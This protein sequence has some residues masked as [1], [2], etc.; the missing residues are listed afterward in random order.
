MVAEMSVPKNRRD[1]SRFE[2]E[3]Q[4]YKLRR[5]V[6][7]LI[8]CDFGFH[9]E[10]YL[11]Q[12]ERYREN[13]STAANVDEIC[14]RWEAKNRSFNVWFIDEEGRAILDLLRKISVEF[15][16]GNSI[17][18]SGTHAKV[19]EYLQ[20]RYHI[21]QAIGYCYALKHEIQYAIE[22][23]PVDINKYERF[24]MMIDK[25]IALYKG[26]RQAS[27]KFLKGSKGNDSIEE[28]TGN[29][30]DGIASLIRKISRI[31][32]AAK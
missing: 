8:L 30:F 25:Q 24:A 9:E 27:N 3:H 16:V 18:P 11:K 13:H 21:D 17:F 10:K 32:S 31:E 6:T 28:T 29:I 1:Q 7:N 19:M 4:F 5:E 20:R 14:A 15:T 23:L 22:I 2:A 12:I 26:V